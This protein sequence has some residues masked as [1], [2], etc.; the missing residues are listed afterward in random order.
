MINKKYLY[1]EVGVHYTNMGIDLETTLRKEFEG[2]WYLWV[3]KKHFVS[4]QFSSAEE[5]MRVLNEFHRDI[6]LAI[7]IGKISPI[8]VDNMGELIFEKDPDQA[9]EFERLTVSLKLNP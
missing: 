5:S 1:P 6:Y 2:I 9:P 8:I 3:F 7:V 4:R